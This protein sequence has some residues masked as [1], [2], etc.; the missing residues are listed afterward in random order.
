MI[1][2]TSS[3]DLGA[4]LPPPILCLG[5]SGVLVGCPLP[6][7]SMASRIGPFATINRQSRQ[8]RKGATVAVRSGAE[9]RLVRA[10]S[11][12]RVAG[13]RARHLE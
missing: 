13:G 5:Y 1:P 7:V 8:A 2:A 4:D 6:A 3:A 10:A 9:V 12:R 11:Q